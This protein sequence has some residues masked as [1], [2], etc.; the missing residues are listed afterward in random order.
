MYN[1]RIDYYDH[2]LKQSDFI[3]FDYADLTKVIA[4]RWNLSLCPNYL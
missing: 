1:K 2:N 4:G 3:E